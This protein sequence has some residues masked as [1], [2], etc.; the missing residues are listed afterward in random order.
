[1]RIREEEFGES[2]GEEGLRLRYE[3]RFFFLEIF[4][5]ERVSSIARFHE[6]IFD[7]R[8]EE[9]HPLWSAGG[10]RWLF[11][12]ESFLPII[13]PLWRFLNLSSSQQFQL[14]PWTVIPNA[15]MT[16]ENITLLLA[17]FYFLKKKRRKEKRLSTCE[18]GKGSDTM[19]NSRPM[20]KFLAY[21]VRPKMFQKKRK[22]KKTREKR[23]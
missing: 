2:S 19:T 15:R 22:E 17:I 3:S 13:R 6:R 5:T 20:R 9:N 14:L 21:F 11:C 23:I 12:T 16:M 8:G 18:K 4:E 7:T 10:Y 1:M